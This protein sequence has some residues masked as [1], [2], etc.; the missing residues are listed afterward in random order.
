MTLVIC[1][2]NVGMSIL[3]I[4]FKLICYGNACRS[5]NFLILLLSLF[6]GDGR[7]EKEV[8]L[9]PPSQILPH[10]QSLLT[11]IIQIQCRCK[12]IRC[13]SEC[14]NKTIDDGNFSR[15][16]KVHQNSRIKLKFIPSQSR[17]SL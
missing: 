16:Q 13:C 17:E 4:A 9:I 8:H 3:C 1:C 15:H 11:P 10:T 6:V 12:K 7:V 14:D 2:H 5:V